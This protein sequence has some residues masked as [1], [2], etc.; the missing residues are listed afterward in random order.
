MGGLGI[1]ANPSL[2]LPQRLTAIARVSGHLNLL[3]KHS[4]VKKMLFE[5]ILSE[6]P[7]LMLVD[8]ID[9][10]DQRMSPHIS[11]LRGMLPAYVTETIKSKAP[12]MLLDNNNRMALYYRGSIIVDADRRENM[13]LDVFV[14]APV[15]FRIDQ[16]T[17]TGLGLE[18]VTT[19]MSVLYGDTLQRMCGTQ[20]RTRDQATTEILNALHMP[21]LT[22][23][24]AQALLDSDIE[25]R[26]LLFLKQA[27]DLLE[28]LMGIP[29][30]IITLP[31]NI[32]MILTGIR[33]ARVGTG[34][35]VSQPML[36][37][38]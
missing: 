28:R 27:M 32:S 18:K 22:R 10:I 12:V 15:I 38:H 2:P 30:K 11:N 5:N 13:G 4:A 24:Q 16:S 7:E 21:V 14:Y 23:E 17:R 26:R 1:Y 25:T 19:R 9:C 34:F 33:V 8:T 6:I 29:E 35:T 20:G 36:N 37:R 3:T 31:T